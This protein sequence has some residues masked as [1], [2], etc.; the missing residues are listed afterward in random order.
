[1]M[2]R[3][4]PALAG[5]NCHTEYGGSPAELDTYPTQKARRGSPYRE[6]T[7]DNI[8][9][10]AANNAAWIHEATGALNRSGEFTPVLWQNVHDLP[11]IFPNAVTLGRTDA[12]QMAAIESLVR[13]RPGRVTAVKDSWARLDLAPLGFDLLF[14]TE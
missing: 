4:P 8:Q 11:P 7:T 10:L 5:G 9:Q 13:R 14:E 1:M 3:K 12:E 6:T 2:R